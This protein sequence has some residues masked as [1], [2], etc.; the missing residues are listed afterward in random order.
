MDS[1][2]VMTHCTEEGR[3]AFAALLIEKLNLLSAK[4]RRNDVMNQQLR[5]IQV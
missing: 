1:G 3:K 4:R 2:L 5:D